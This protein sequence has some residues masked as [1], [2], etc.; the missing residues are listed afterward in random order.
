[1]L[2]YG[3]Y[4]SRNH[5]RRYDA[6]QISSMFDGI[7]H[8]GVYMGIGN[9]LMVTQ[10]TNMMV[11]V[12]TGRAWFDHTWTL[13]DA[14]L[15][16]TIP[17][18]EVILNR[19]DAVV[20]E[21]NHE[22]SVRANSIKVV[23]GTPSSN[24]ARPTLTNTVN[25]HQH[26][27]AYVYVG[28]GVTSIRTANITNMVGTSAC[29]FVTGVIQ[30]MNIDALVAQ[31]GDQ[32][33][34]FYEKETADMTKT[35]AFWKQQWRTW[36]EAQTREIQNAYLSWER[37][38]RAWYE[39]QTTEMINTKNYWQQLWEAWFYQYVNDNIKDIA[40][41]KIQNQQK[42]DE[43]FNAL[44]VLVDGDVATNLANELI[45]VKNQLKVLEKFKYDMVTEQ[46]IYDV[47]YD[48]TYRHYENVTDSSG[49]NVLD[50]ESDNIVS[51]TYMSEPILDSNGLEIEARMKFAI[52]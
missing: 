12:G 32:W 9:K 40:D 47:L 7:I 28:A 6:L 17:Q 37:E 26:P 39:S 30:S 44:K 3:F 13:N 36:F 33:K 24:P 43:W 50:N 22:T 35:N 11:L 27:L 52:L 41:W 46:T 16:I 8:D 49:D 18:S 42:F 51:G 25:V 31:W 29:P 15:P 48:N 1:M 34:A 23:K 10:G 14:P 2:T 5:D 20:L 21:V 19:I 38:W 4:N 45:E